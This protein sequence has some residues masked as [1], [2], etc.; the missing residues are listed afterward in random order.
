MKFLVVG[1]GH[2]E[3]HEVTVAS[4]LTALGY[5][6]ET[7]FWSE[8]LE[9][10]SLFSELSARLQ[11][12]LLFGPRISKINYRLISHAHAFEPDVIFLY[13]GTHIFPRSLQKIRTLLPNVKLVGYNNDDPFSPGAEKLLWR[14][15]LNCV[16]LYD[17]VLAYRKHNIA[18]F[19]KAGAKRVEMLRSWYSTKRNFPVLLSDKDLLRFECDVVFVGHYEDDF[20]VEYLESLAKRGISVKIFGPGYDW[21]PVLARSDALKHLVPV[22]LVWGSDYNK[23]LCGA[24]IAVCF[25]S[26]LNRDT[27][28]RRCFEIPATGTFML[29]ERTHDLVSLYNEGT[30]V[31]FF[32]SV[33]EFTEKVQFYL[34]NDTHRKKIA[35]GG[36]ARLLADGHDVESRMRQLATILFE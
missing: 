16:P 30:E 12:K 28:T 27:Y 14:H 19:V 7:F 17:L 9:T 4:A 36:S 29:A 8:S 18:E 22:D 11:N 24:K 20:R 10:K 21:D 25:L 23:A 5:E 34:A 1:D 3:L 26:K 32:G 35:A 2:S 33:G 13:R 31:E 15:F 6:V